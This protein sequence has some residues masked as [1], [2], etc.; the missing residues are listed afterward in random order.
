MTEGGPMAV[1]QM[2][3]LDQILT[4]QDDPRLWAAALTKHWPKPDDPWL[5][6]SPIDEAPR[7]AFGVGHLPIDEGER[8]EWGAHAM[9]I[10]ERWS[11]ERV[12]ARHFKATSGEPKYPHY[13]LDISRPSA[14]TNLAWVHAG[15]NPAPLV[16][17]GRT[18]VWVC[19]E[20]EG[21]IE[22]EEVVSWWI[23]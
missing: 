1:L 13:I 11:L 19:H 14:G 2:Y 17:L 5:G 3:G 20:D 4:N 23:S 16:G 10:N 12:D 22:T 15:D 21:W 7:I 6:D 9:V 18:T 8:R